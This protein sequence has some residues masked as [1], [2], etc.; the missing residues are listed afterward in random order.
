MRILLLLIAAIA[1]IACGA[2]DPVPAAKYKADEHFI[3][4]RQA[5][6]DPTPG[7]PDAI[8]I[9]WYGCPHCYEF[10]PKITAWK[11]N[12]ASDV[13]FTRIP[14]SLGRPQGILHSKAYYTAQALGMLEDMHPRIFDAI[15]RQR[16]PLAT[17]A[18]IEA[19]FVGAGVLPE[20]FRETFNSFAV[21]GKVQQAEAVI[22]NLGI[23]A[24]PSMSVD[25]K[26]WTSTSQAGGYDG[27]L[28]VVDY[29]VEESRR[30]P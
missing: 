9:F 10:E 15:H 4:A 13:V 14:A 26:T 1:P 5:S 30:A 24:V 21:E 6:A 3:P 23:R 17:E 25:L 18:S 7:R 16:Q 28:D 8:E 2:S 20:V 27:V 12:L 11:S 22:R 19:V 29:L